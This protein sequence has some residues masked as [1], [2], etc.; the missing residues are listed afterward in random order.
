M[1]TPSAMAK[2]LC[3]VVSLVRACEHSIN[4]ETGELASVELLNQQVATLQKVVR[5]GRRANRE[6]DARAKE[7]T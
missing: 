5:A 1:M 2:A 6:A 4:Y 3:E 7:A